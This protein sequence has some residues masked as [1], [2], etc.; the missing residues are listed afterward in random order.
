M[1][2]E[3]YGSRPDLLPKFISRIETK[4]SSGGRVLTWNES[5]EL[6]DASLNR[7]AHTSTTIQWEGVPFSTRSVCED[8]DDCHQ[9]IKRLMSCELSEKSDVVFFWGNLVIPSIILPVE[10]ALE[11]LHEI[12][13]VFPDLWIFAPQDQFLIECRQDGQVTMSDIPRG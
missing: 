5:R 8:E 10:L 6:E 1:Q 9:L 13:E 4:G 11:H 2:P 3:H 12:L 7:F